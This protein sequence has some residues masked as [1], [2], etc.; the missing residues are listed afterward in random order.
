[1]DGDAT[2]MKKKKGLAEMQGPVSWNLA[3]FNKI[4]AWWILRSLH[5]RFDFSCSHARENDCKRYIESKTHKELSALQ[6]SNRSMS[7]FLTKSTE[8]DNQWAVTRTEVLM[9]ELIA[10]YIIYISISL[11]MVNLV[12]VIIEIVIEKSL[13]IPKG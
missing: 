11:S 6:K 5:D 8:T 9:C 10:K 13:K 12:I 7:S 1:V 3:D 4:T 2:P